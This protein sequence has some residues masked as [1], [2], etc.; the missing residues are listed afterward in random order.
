VHPVHHPAHATGI[1]EEHLAT[2][3]PEASVALLP[4]QDP[5]AGIWVEGRFSCPRIPSPHGCADASPS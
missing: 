1:D 3:V 4:R 5:Q 2:P